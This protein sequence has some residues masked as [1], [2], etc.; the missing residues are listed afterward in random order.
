[1]KAM[2]ATL[3]KGEERRV[4]GGLLVVLEGVD[5]AGKSS[6]LRGLADFCARQKILHVVS[7]EP[8]QGR[9]GRE[10][11]RTA[12]TGRLSLEEE[13][14]LFLK[15]R[16]EH[17]ETLIRPSLEQG[18]VVLLDRYYFS[19]VA[20]QGARGA[21]PQEVLERNEAFAPPPDLM[22]LLDCDPRVSLERVRG[23]GN[24]DAFEKLE[25]LEA[26]R[27]LFLSLRRPYIRVVRAEGSAQGVAQECVCEVAGLF[28]RRGILVQGD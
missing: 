20:Y 4:P 26:V 24:P 21:D 7:R 6:V 10:I 2:E 12:V 15:D 9:W 18:A 1:M 14:E 22:L 17:V 23:R 11:R 8:T 19:S 16:R 25:A 5:G 27:A 28:Q 13:L 3:E